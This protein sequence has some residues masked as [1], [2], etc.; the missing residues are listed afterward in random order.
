MNK[1]Y[2]DFD[3]CIVNTIKVICD[4]YNYDYQ[5]MD[6]YKPVHWANINSW[7]FKELTLANI[8]TINSYF[9]QKRFFNVAECM[10]NSKE[11]INKLLDDYMI[12]IVSI[13]SSANLKAKY[14]WIINKLKLNVDFLPIHSGLHIDK[15]HIDMSDGILIDDVAANLNT[16]NAKVKICFGDK[17]PWNEKWKGIR[18]ANWYDV[19]R[20]ITGKEMM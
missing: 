16:S 14:D 6:G 7:A 2:M 10:D 13:G 19:Y 18:C 12:Q 8:D 20:E 15:S 5:Y 3:G 4:L 11:V 17:Y 9:N 1:I